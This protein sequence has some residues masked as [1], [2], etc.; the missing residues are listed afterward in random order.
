M[1]FLKKIKNCCL[2]ILDLL[3]PQNVDLR[4]LLEHSEPHVL[5]SFL[6]CHNRPCKA[7]VRI[8]WGNVY[9]RHLTLADCLVSTSGLT[10][11]QLCHNVSPLKMEYKH[12]KFFPCCSSL[13][14]SLCIFLQDVCN[15]SVS[16]GS[17]I[18]LHMQ[19]EPNK[20]LFKKIISIRISF[21]SYFAPK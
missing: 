16:L 7:V 21:R 4:Q 18:K 15:L 3:L 8:V 10:M 20:L 13:C 11:N 1:D 17:W 9:S 14:L 19:E 12:I 6:K 2:Q 5:C